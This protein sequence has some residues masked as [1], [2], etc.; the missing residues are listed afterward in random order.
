MTRRAARVDANH[1]AIVAAFRRMGVSCRSLASVGQG[2]PDLICSNKR[3]TWLCEVKDGTKP[4]S[5]RRLTFAQVEFHASW[6]GQIYIVT[7]IDDVYDCV[8]NAAADAGRA[9]A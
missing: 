9:R 2:M 5:A 1:E 3:A 8:L 6:R 7:S 4:P